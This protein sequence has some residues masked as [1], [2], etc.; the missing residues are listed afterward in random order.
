VLEAKLKKSVTV[1]TNESAQWNKVG[2]AAL[3]TRVFDSHGPWDDEG[4]RLATGS[5]ARGAGSF[6]A[7]RNTTARTNEKLVFA[8]LQIS[9]AALPVR[10]PK[11]G[12]RKTAGRQFADHIRF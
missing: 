3:S 11:C 8:E 5:D 7:N 9:F 4:C 1:K 10:G 6:V 2:G 12:F